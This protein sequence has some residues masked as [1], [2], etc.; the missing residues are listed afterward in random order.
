[1]N[2]PT[3]APPFDAV[4]FGGGGGNN[5]GSPAIATIG[6]KILIMYYCH[7]VLVYYNIYFYLCFYRYRQTGK[8]IPKSGVQKRKS[9]F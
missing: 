1:M 9:Y 3:G 8:S 6:G 7:N 4:D 5:N 2:T